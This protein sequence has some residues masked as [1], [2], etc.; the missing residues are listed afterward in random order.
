MKS[1]SRCV[2]DSGVP[3]NSKIAAE[4][5][6]SCMVT[7]IMYNELAYDWRSTAEKMLQKD[8]GRW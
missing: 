1:V 7:V 3:I 4:A 8:E 2:N 6:L 5:F